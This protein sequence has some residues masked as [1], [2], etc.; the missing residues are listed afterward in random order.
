MAGC[1]DCAPKDVTRATPAYRRALWLVVLLNLATGAGEVVVG[2]VAQSQSLKADALDFLGDGSITLLALLA[3]RWGAAWRAR[4]A[5]AQGVFL[6]VL[7]VGVLA[8]T[9][10][11]VLIANEPEAAPMGL[12]AFIGLAANVSSALLL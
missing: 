3:T 2:F 10:Y 8:A 1:D 6:A 9:A 11:R 12:M 7:G 5:A 4:M